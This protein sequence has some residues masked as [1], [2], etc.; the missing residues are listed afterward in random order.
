MQPLDLLER[1]EEA[2]RWG[3]RA[4]EGLRRAL[5]EDDP[6]TLYAWHLLLEPLAQL[7]SEQEF[8]DESAALIAACER[9]LPPDHLT[10]LLARHSHAYGLTEL[11]RYEEAES[12]ARRVL[13]GRIRVQD[14][15][16][17][18]ALSAL[19]LSALSLSALSLSALSLSAL[20]LSALIALEL[21]RADEAI[22][23]FREVA[24]RRERVL[25]PRHPFVVEDR[26]RLAQAVAGR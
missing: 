7:G 16:F 11:G 20:S 13:E 23:I 14:P 3:R 25:G 17:P 4:V 12:L 26:E 24:E 9:A 15:D 1:D 18:L 6:E 21:G 8:D 22:A 10:T 5:G 19:S 2:V